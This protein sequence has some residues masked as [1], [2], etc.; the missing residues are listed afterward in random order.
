MQ[1]LTFE[2]ESEK[3]LRDVMKKLRD[4]YGVT[5]ELHVRKVAEG[6]WRLQVHSEKELRE[7]TLEKFSKWRV[8]L[9]D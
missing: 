1:Y 3:E 2:F 4:H 8:E 6:R 7:S 5:G 9:A